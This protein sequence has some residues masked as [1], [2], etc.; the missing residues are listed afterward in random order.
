MAIVLTLPATLPLVPERA[1]LPALLLGLLRLAN[2]QLPS[3]FKELA[4]DRT[5]LAILLAASAWFG[6]LPQAMAIL[7]LAVL[8]SLL[9]R[10]GSSQITRD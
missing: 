1:F 8:G 7:S 4:A 3:G 9:F 2:R 5:L 10:S 6:V